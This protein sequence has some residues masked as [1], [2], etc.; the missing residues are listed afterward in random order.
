M[1]VSWLSRALTLGLLAIIL[2]LAARGLYGAPGAAVNIRWQSS[3]DAAERQRLETEWQLVDG[4]EVSPST[5]RYDLTAPS[6]GR[7]RAI[8][9]HPAVADTHDIDRQRYTVEAR[10]TARRHGLIT[11]GGAVAVGLVDRLAMLLGAFAGFYVLVRSSPRLMAR[12]GP[13]N[14]VAAPLTPRARRSGAIALVLAPA[15]CLIAYASV[16]SQMAGEADYPPHV[17]FARQLAETG[18][19]LPHFGYHAV[20]IMVRA[21]TPADWV[22]AAGIVTLGGVAACAIVVAWW[23]RGALSTSASALLVAAALVP[24]ALCVLQP[25]L[26]LDPTRYDAWLFGYFPPNQ[27]HSPTTLFSKPFALLLLGLG[28]MVVWPAQGTRAGRRRML[29]SAALVVMSALVKPNFIMAF[30]PALSALAVLHW[31]HTDWYWLG[32]SF[33]LPT[34]AVLAW[35]YDMAY[36]LTNERS[37]VI[38]APLSVI[39]LRSPTDV[40]T[41]GWRLAASVLFP[42]AAVVCFP[43]V[44]ADR[45]VQLG[46]ATFLI[47]AAFGYL[48]AEGGRAND[49]NFLWSGQLAAFVLFAATAVAVLR[50][51]A[52]GGAGAS[53]LGRFALCGGV[54][55][56]HVTSGIQHLY[57]TWLA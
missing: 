32:I 56:W 52:T 53:R 39:G 28:P 55:L 6:E 8:V 21:L 50:A 30:L 20:V 37:G 5:W 3:V 42:L 22:A 16:V 57:A 11:V 26:P 54:F 34:I 7:L 18:T 10:R 38:L 40:V 12:T 48:L 15:V 49:G 25:V 35:Q 43:S 31:R 33:A 9:E 36:T 4:Q 1:T 2:P 47:G 44:R 46:W 17:E 24:A 45:R 13:P 14:A 23:L 51:A 29:A 41:L 19:L 27:W